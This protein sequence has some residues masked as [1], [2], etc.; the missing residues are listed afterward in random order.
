MVVALAVGLSGCAAQH[1]TRPAAKP[2]HRHTTSTA[3]VPALTATAPSGLRQGVLPAVG[4]A[5]HVSSGGAALTVILR[6][7]IDPLHGSGAGLPPGTRAVAVLVQIRNAGPAIYDSSATGDFSVVVSG[8]NVTPVFARRGICRTPQ[9][10]F[11]R[12]ITAGED[13]VGCVVFA[14]ANG[15]TVEAVTFSPHARAKG[16]LTWAP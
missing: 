6:R 2:A 1:P 9:N 12:Y 8:G 15:A 4:G 11:D 7:V 10:D 14:V 5:Q 16:R 13:R 3:Q